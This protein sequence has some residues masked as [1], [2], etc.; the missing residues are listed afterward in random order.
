MTPIGRTGFKSFL[1][2]LVTVFLL[3]IRGDTLPKKYEVKWNFHKF[4][5]DK[6]GFPVASYSS[7]IEPDSSLLIKLLESEL[8]K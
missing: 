6:Q 3:R 2:Q 1:M 7:E 8:K 4:L 5:I